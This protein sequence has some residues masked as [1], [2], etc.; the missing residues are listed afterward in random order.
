MSTLLVSL[1]LGC[2]W[3]GDAPEEKTEV[4]PLPKVEDRSRKKRPKE[5]REGRSRKGKGAPTEPLPDRADPC[6]AIDGGAYVYRF[7]FQGETHEVPVFVGDSEGPRDLAVLL[8]GGKGGAQSILKKTLFHDKALEE[9]F[10]VAA[11]TGS[12]IAGRGARW[13]TGKFDDELEEHLRP[14]EEIRD[15]VAFLDAMTKGLRRDLCV[16]NVVTVGFSSGG[17]MTHRWGC[18]GTQVDVVMSAAGELLVPEKGCTPRPVLG[19]VGKLDRVYREGPNP[20]DPTQPSAPET[21]EIWAKINRCKGEPRKRR[22]KDA[23]CMVYEDCK[24]PTQL[25]V[26][27]DM[28]HGFP[29]PWG[30]DG[31]EFNGRDYGWDWFQDDVK[32]R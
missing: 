9:G 3:W 19:Y 16:D 10:A 17:Q 28:P 20:K 7:A 14:G 30:D 24:R 5:K 23:T 15:D 29:V 25:C 22:V 11:P 31:V 21:I 27:D 1:L 26:V 12:D 4:L 18:E 6:G 32:K 8:H 13:N 2:G